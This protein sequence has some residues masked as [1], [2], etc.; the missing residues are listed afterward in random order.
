MHMRWPIKK[1]IAIGDHQIKKELDVDNGGTNNSI[2][3][4]QVHTHT[5]KHQNRN[6]NPKP[7]DAKKPYTYSTTT[8]RTYLLQTAAQPR[9]QRT[10]WPPIALALTSDNDLLHFRNPRTRGSQSTPLIFP[11]QSLIP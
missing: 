9:P 5:T 10:L 11:I 3:A 4:I 2:K 7:Q 1:Y 8:T 6:R